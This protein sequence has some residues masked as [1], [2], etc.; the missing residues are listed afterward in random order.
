MVTDPSTGHSRRDTFLIYGLA[1]TFLVGVHLA[2]NGVLGFHIDE[3]YYLA[4]GQHLA[5]GYVD[6]PPVVPLLA[7][8]ETGLL[9]VT[10]WTLRLLPALLGGVN[11]IICGAYVRKLGGS[12]GL[13]LLVML[14]GISMPAIIGTWLYQ[15]VIFDQVM[16]MAAIY[17]FLS[18]V[19]QPEPRT[20]ILLGVVLGAGLE[21]KFTIV[22][23]V[24]GFAVAV[25]C[26]PS[27]RPE[28]RTRYPWI[29]GFLA[30]IIWAP[31]LIWQAASGFPTVTYVFNHQGS[32]GGSGSF[33]IGFL[34]LLALLTPLWIT[35]LI[36]L[37][38]A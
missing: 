21:V 36:S 6:F 7:R 17:L 2:T 18:L 10:P 3:L 33:F 35:G 19:L 20:W 32:T 23:L 38:R 34:V 15:T 26:T 13:Q 30:L 31:N 11:V 1:S 24:V 12:L 5:F 37:L 14:I 28:L 22:A 4:C 25:L 29:A 9:G 8:I 16:W 27:L